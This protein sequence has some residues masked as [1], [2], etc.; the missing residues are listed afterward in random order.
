V[1]SDMKKN[2]FLTGNKGCGKSTMIASAL[3]ENLGKAGGFLTVREIGE[4]GDARAFWLRQPGRDDGRMIIDYSGQP[5]TMHPEVFETLGV[6]LVQQAREYDFVVLDEIGGF[7]ILTDAF[8]N[9]LMELLQ[10][11]VPCIG[12]V[13]APGAATR[14]IQRLGLGD[15][16]V[17]R[18]EELHRW[19][20]LDENTLLYHCGQ[21]DPEGLRLAQVWAAEYVS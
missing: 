3:G 17:Q 14:M 12:V 5:Y 16:Y 6:R 4:D 2:L 19:M 21:F 9:A 18:S 7:E 11:E 20:E 15:L 13:K 1:P 8:L 10:S